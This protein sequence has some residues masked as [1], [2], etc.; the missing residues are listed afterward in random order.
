MTITQI[1]DF[2]ARLLALLPSQFANALNLRALVESFGEECQLIEDT[3]WSLIDQVAIDTATGV[4]LDNIG[5]IV[6]LERTSV[7]DDTYRQHLRAFIL[8]NRSDGR[9]NALIEIA[10]RIQDSIPSP[11]DN[12][13]LVEY[14]EH[15]TPSF[16]LQW[17]KFN[18]LTGTV[19][20]YIRLLNRLIDRA[21]PAGVE[22][23][24]VEG[25][26]GAFRFGVNERGFGLG[27]LGRRLDTS[28]YGG[29]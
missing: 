23:R 17:E 27:R 11:A 24:V 15:P 5:A 13:A 16:T 14:F 2:T 18:S 20:V 1:N 21:A 10:Q 22:S 12:A 29:S 25:V 19:S 8:A 28:T 3:L 7:T 26:T 9:A 4:Q 6:G